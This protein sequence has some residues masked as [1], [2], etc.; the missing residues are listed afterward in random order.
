MKYWTFAVALLGMSVPSYAQEIVY[1][2]GRVVYSIQCEGHRMFHYFDGSR[3]QRL[4][5]GSTAEVS[6]DKFIRF[7]RNGDCYFQV[8]VNYGTIVDGILY[9]TDMEAGNYWGNLDGR[10]IFN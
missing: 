2:H 10:S 8:L 7:L 3:L 6:F 4:C 5:I 9:A 1:R